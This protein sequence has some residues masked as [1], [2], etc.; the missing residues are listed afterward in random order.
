MTNPAIKPARLLFTIALT[1]ACYLPGLTGHFIFDDGANIRINPFLQI[2]NLDFSSLWEAATWG[3]TKPLG[4]P[5]SMASFAIDY[6]FFGMN[7]YYFKATNLAIHSL[8]GLLAFFLAKLLF[9]LHLRI[10]CSADDNAASWAALAVAAIWLLHPL[11]LTDVLY[12]VQRMTSL[13]AL[14]TLAGLALYLRGRRSLLDGATSGWFAIIAAL[15]VFTPLAALCKESGVLLPW[16]V[17]VTEAALLRWRTP[18]LKSQRLLTAIVGLSTLIPA[19]FGLFYV[20]NH[21]GVI[22]D[23]YA[24]RDFSLTERL[25]TEARALWFYVRM[26]VLPSMPEMGLHHDDFLISRGLLMPWTTLP[27]ISGWLMVIVAAFVL[28]NRQPLITFGIAFFLAGHAME[29]TI[30]PLEPVFEHRNY[31]PMLGILLPLA[32]YALNPELHSSSVRV[33]RYAFVL[34]VILFAGLT[35]ARAQQWGDT[36]MMR[37]LEVERHPRSV[38]AHTDLANLYDNLPPNS[39]EN[40]IDLY[41]KARFHYQQAADNGPSSIA[42]L[43]GILVMNA[44]RELPVDESSFESLEQRLATVPFGPP[45]MNTLIGAARDM[46]DGHIVVDSRVVDRIY[47]AAMSNPL[48]TVASRSQIIFEFGNLPPQIRPKMEPSR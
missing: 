31:L 29:S 1:V 34:M 36:L 8:N 5:I 13:S 46:A 26:I 32:Y 30:I 47:R 22:L 25:M 14:F 3:G 18:N 20:V 45:N 17:L 24:W 10:R 19:V 21:P 12:V 37:T 4:R 7:P 42:G 44:H 39:H 2:N 41:T 43:F 28:R 27:A 38:R 6:Y 23:G 9:G 48:L 11:N 33:R 40:A 15:L 35:A 16:F